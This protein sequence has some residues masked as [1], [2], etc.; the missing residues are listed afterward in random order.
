MNIKSKKGQN[1]HLCQ[2]ILIANCPYCTGFSSNSYHSAELEEN[3]VS[4]DKDIIKC[5]FF[6]Q[7][8]YSLHGCD[9]TAT[10]FSKTAEPVTIC[11]KK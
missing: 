10:F 6:S 7:Q 9:I 8:H 5:Q 2:N 3:I 1:Y 4:N 11:K